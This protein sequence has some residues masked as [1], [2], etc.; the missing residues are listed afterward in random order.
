MR[1]I[2][3]YLA[4][5]GHLVEDHPEL[6][7][8]LYLAIAT[9]IDGQ[10]AF[11]ALSITRYKQRL[12]VKQ[13]NQNKTSLPSY[14]STNIAWLKIISRLVVNAHIDRGRLVGHLD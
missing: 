4:H 13:Q 14:D 2:E 12:G 1:Q 5:V 9:R 8:L 10:L 6:A 3:R 7:Y 11:V